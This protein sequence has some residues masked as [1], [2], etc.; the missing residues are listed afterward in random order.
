[1][2][3]RPAPVL[4]LVSRLPFPLDDGWKT[5]TYHVI[6]EIAAKFPTTVLIRVDERQLP[7]VDAF[8]AT[9]P[10]GTRLEV[11]VEAEPRVGPLLR[12]ALG[13]TPVYVHRIQTP[14]FMRRAFE[15]AA[16]QRF[17]SCVCVYTYIF[18]IGRAHELA[19]Q[20]FVDTHNVDSQLMTRYASALPWSPRRLF[21]LRTA[22]QLRQWEAVVFRQAKEAWVCSDDERR[23]LAI[24]G[25]PNAR[26]AANGI[27]AA[28]LGAVQRA[29]IAGR[30]LFFGRL[31]Y[32]PNADAVERLRN[33]IMP[34][35]RQRVPDATLRIVG[36]GRHAEE[37]KHDAPGVEMVGAV[38]DVRTELTLADICVVPLR[39][40]GGTRLKVL[41]ALG[42]G[43]P[44]VATALAVEGLGLIPGKHYVAAET[45]ASLATA[46]AELLLDHG[47]KASLSE[48]GRLAVMT[49][50][51]WS[52]TL[53]PLTEALSR[54]PSR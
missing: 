39:V 41:E 44:I 51:Q 33:A 16:A 35:V 36:P 23:M 7:H 28:S 1:M 30:I 5:R 50:F 2:L 29:P 27:Q 37:W 45:D 20:V 38:P 3:L 8:R 17:A 11:V 46:A 34:Q 48:E 54:T 9:L 47:R 25:F 18:P 4:V 15:L 10:E 26:V 53:R 31:D 52:A 14:R 13:S 19:E 21:A 43:V 49:A 32:F 6:H 24:A 22:R 42:A 12:A 40:G